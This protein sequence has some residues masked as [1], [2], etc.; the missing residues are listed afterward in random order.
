MAA[1]P[2]QAATLYAMGELDGAE[3]EAVTANWRQ[4]YEH[5][6]EPAFSYNTGDG[7]LEGAAARGAHYRW[8]GIPRELVKQWD[9][10]RKRRAAVI[11]NLGRVKA[12]TA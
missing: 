3:L 1:P 6:L 7:W 2:H 9:A 4:A 8:A 5:A 10:E 12:A 11:R